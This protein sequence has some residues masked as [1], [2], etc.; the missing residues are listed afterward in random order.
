MIQRY[1]LDTSV[2]INGWQKRYHPDVFPALWN[3][4]H[5][6]ISNR[7]VFSCEEVYLEIQAKDDA[8]FEWVKTRKSAFLSP[9]DKVLAE[10]QVVMTRFQNFAAKGGSLNRAD[11]W[12]VAQA[13]VSG[14]IVVTDEQKVEKQKPTKPPKLPNVCE[15]MDV[16]WMTPI[17][18]LSAAKMKF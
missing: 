18:F 8:L 3:R 7:S 5:E 2:L 12:I 14:A 1:C 17:E 11:P 15:A 6:L 10:M 16:K 9:D 4:L 13:R